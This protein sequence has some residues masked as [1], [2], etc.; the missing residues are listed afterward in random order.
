M[1][2]NSK[3]LELIRSNIYNLSSKKDLESK[4]NLR[5]NCKFKKCVFEKLYKEDFGDIL[6]KVLKEEPLSFRLIINMDFKTP[7]ESKIIR[8]LSEDLYFS[9]PYSNKVFKFFSIRQVFQFIQ[10]IY[11]NKIQTEFEKTVDEDKKDDSCLTN[12]LEELSKIKVFNKNEDPIK[13]SLDLLGLTEVFI[14][15]KLKENNPQWEAFNAAFLLY[16]NYI[17][18]LTLEELLEKEKL[19]FNLNSR[20]NNNNDNEIFDIDNENEINNFDVISDK[21]LSKKQK[22]SKKR[23]QTEMKDENLEININNNENKNEINDNSFLNNNKKKKLNDPIIQNNDDNDLNYSID[24]F[25]NEELNKNNELHDI[26]EEKL[27]NKKSNIRQ[28]DLS[29]VSAQYFDSENK[30]SVSN[31]QKQT[32]KNIDT[33]ATNKNRVRRT[34]NEIYKN[35]K[36]NLSFHYMFQSIIPE[37]EKKKQIEDYLRINYDVSNDDLS[38]QE[39]V[40]HYT[41]LIHRCLVELL[42]TFSFEESRRM[43]KHFN[44]ILKSKKLPVIS[45]PNFIKDKVKE[46]P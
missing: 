39:K 28:L 21:N 16:R 24:N 14:I 35:I 11:N 26:I 5:I 29:N 23:T 17:E 42:N 6:E 4:K 19:F 20:N 27:T 30:S 33:I 12:L 41:S 43:M 36:S 32:N 44:G 38:D 9:V 22:K 37:Q 3:R 31:N 18:N 25:E 46:E 7:D 15:R 45:L 13:E 40:V 34:Q 1:I 10:K 8:L 2:D